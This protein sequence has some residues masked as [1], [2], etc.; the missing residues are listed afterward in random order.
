MLRLSLIPLLLA[1]LCA[2]AQDPPYLTDPGWKPLLNGVDLKGWHAMDPSKPHE[3]VAARGIRFDR[4]YSPKAL[5]F[6]GE[7]GDRMING[8]AGRTQNFVTDEK[9]GDIELYLEFMIPR[10]AN[11][12]VYLQGLYEIQ[13]LDSFGVADPT[14]GDCGAVYHEWVNGK[15]KGGSAPRVNAMRNA[16]EWQ[17]YRIW[18][19]APRFDAAGKKVENARFLRVVFNGVMIQDNVEVPNPTRAHMPLVEAASNPLMIQGDHG[20][21]AFRNIYWRPLG[22]LPER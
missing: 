15:A 8:K 12:G 2:F 21:V 17:S 10:G 4:M 5:S 22:E 19:R 16:G 6:T 9:F 20:P 3:W 1:S 7:S 18:F 11:S 14:T 13:I